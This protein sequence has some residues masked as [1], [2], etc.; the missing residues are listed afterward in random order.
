VAYYILRFAKPA[1]KDCLVPAAQ[2][3]I[4]AGNAAAAKDHADKI[5]KNGSSGKATLQLFNEIGL[6]STRSAQGVWSF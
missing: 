5:A 3:M 2:H 6:V 4:E 1:K